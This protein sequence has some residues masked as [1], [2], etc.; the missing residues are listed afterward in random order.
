M[1]NITTAETRAEV[2]WEKQE[3]TIIEAINKIADKAAM[4]CKE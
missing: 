2:V 4:A 1:E 3:W